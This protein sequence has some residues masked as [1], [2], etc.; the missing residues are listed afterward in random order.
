MENL[1][2]Q[3]PF[4]L[5]VLSPAGRTE[6][7]GASLLI[8]VTSSFSQSGASPSRGSAGARHIMENKN[9]R[10]VFISGQVLGCLLVLVDGRVLIALGILLSIP[11]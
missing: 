9:A 5:S 8:P 3:S 10:T 6:A 11:A 7:R 1:N 4:R 2:F